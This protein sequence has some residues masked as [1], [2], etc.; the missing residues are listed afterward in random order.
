[1]KKILSVIALFGL[2]NGCASGPTPYNPE[3]VAS[4]DI[5]NTIKTLDEDKRA[6]LTFGANWCSDSRALATAYQQEP[7]QSLVD[8]NF[9]IVFIDIGERNRNLDLAQKF[10]AP[11]MG[12][13]PSIVVVDANGEI[14]FSS[15]AEDL[16]NAA[17]MTE[18]D[19][20]DYFDNLVE[21]ELKWKNYG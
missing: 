15:K 17:A 14:E 18:Q 1:M 7:L 8:D 5:S 6:L 2:L 20:Y 13:I 21:R 19:I 9:D 3:R 11:V 10:N 12:G 16:K 4:N